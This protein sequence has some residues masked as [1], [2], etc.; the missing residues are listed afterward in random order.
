MSIT[1]GEI[2]ARLTDLGFE[3]DDVTEEEYARIFINSLNRAGEILYSTVMLPIEDYLL[4]QQRDPLDLTYEI[5]I[6]SN[7]RLKKI[8]KITDE[9]ENDDIIDIAYELV[10][11]YTLLAAH[12]AWLDDDLTKATIYWNE[13]DSLKNE[14]IANASKPRG[15]VI[16]GGVRI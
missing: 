4:K 2:K 3:E 9:T 16:K 13:F 11:L 10:P 7:S 8:T 6:T 1:Y 5:D 14:L 12:Y 15:A